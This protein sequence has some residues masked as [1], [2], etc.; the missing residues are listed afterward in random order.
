[1]HL[2]HAHGS[3]PLG[4]GSWHPGQHP[5]STPCTTISPQPPVTFD[6]TT[7]AAIAKTTHFKSRV[8]AP[9]M[10]VCPMLAHG[11][12]TPILSCRGGCHSTPPPQSQY[13]HL[14]PPNSLTLASLVP[15]LATK[16]THMRFGTPFSSATT[17][18]LNS[19][20]VLQPSESTLGPAPCPALLLPCCACHTH[21]R[22]LE[23]ED[24][25]V[26]EQNS[27]PPAP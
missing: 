3:T 21:P 22:V 17:A 8:P 14:S 24:S 27:V 5:P 9:P 4:G 13:P 25:A 16:R 19:A 23:A 12:P 20:K 18:L 6:P 1:L 10:H 26:R 15:M 7:P 2:T 11:A